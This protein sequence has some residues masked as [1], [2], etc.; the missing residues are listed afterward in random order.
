M[1]NFFT[2]KWLMSFFN[3]L[4]FKKKEDGLY[5]EKH[6]DT[7]AVLKSCFYF[8]HDDL[9][10]TFIALYLSINLLHVFTFLLYNGTNY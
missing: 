8:Y 9:N 3:T 1:G 10:I 6:L 5:F 7:H 4:P 2:G